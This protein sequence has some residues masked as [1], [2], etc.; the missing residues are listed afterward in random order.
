MKKTSVLLVAMLCCAALFIAGCPRAERLAD[1]ERGDSATGQGDDHETSQGS[2]SSTEAPGE[3]PVYPGA[4][5]LGSGRKITVTGLRVEGAIDGSTYHV[6][7]DYEDVA[8]W[9]RDR[10]SEALELSATIS[11]ERG[12]GRGTIFVL[13]SGTGTGA[14]ATVAAADDGP[15]TTVNIGNWEGSILEDR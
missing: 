15:G 6:E 2:G 3:I 5:Q 11:G 8:A 9:Y 12:S 1:P 14:A 7:A 13:L 10:L 4:D